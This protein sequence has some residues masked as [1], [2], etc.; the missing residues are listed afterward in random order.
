VTADGRVV[1]ASADEHPDLFWGLRGGGG[2]FGVDTEF[3]FRLHPTTG[4]AL[5]VELTFP[6]DR[7]VAPVRAWRDLLSEA[8]R[9]ATL[10]VDAFATEGRPAVVVGFV[11]VG[12]MAEARRYLET[13]RAAIG[14][15]ATENV[16]ELAYVD[17]QQVGD[18]GHGHGK[19][20]YSTGHYLTELSDAAIDAFL[21]RGLPAG[22]A[23]PDWSRQPG[24]G[25]QAYGGAIADVGAEDSA[26]SFRDTL[27]EWFG[28]STWLDADEDAERMAAVRAWGKALDPFAVGVYVNVLADPGSD[29]VGR[30]YRKGHATRLA[31]LNRPW[32][33][34]NVFHLNQNIK[35]AAAPA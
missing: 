13:F 32:D 4:R 21:S 34:D 23:E 8:P 18:A 22:A 7:A 28:G 20:R 5:S 31:E 12:D 15:G 3:R 6:A 27:V 16:E 14:P 26:F 29:G 25:F 33:P 19:R 9:S 1:R 10:T 11:W 35:P 30:A 2:N 17:L 24:S